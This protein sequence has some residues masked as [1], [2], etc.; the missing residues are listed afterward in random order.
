MQQ[1]RNKKLL[2]FSSVVIKQINNRYFNFDSK[3]AQSRLLI[4]LGLLASRHEFAL[5]RIKNI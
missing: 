4:M 3:D 1:R 5:R 2:H